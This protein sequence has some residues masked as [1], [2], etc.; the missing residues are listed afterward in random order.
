MPRS[1]RRG[2][3]LAWAGPGETGAGLEAGPVNVST[4]GVRAGACPARI[5]PAGGRPRGRARRRF[6]LLGGSRPASMLMPEGDFLGGVLAPR[7]RSDLLAGGAAPRSDP[8][9]PSV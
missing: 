3:P 4:T 1:H 5:M 6:P 9:S 2:F 8:P 7:H